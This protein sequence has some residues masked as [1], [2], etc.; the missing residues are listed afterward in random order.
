MA[1]D[2][3]PVNKSSR[4]GQELVNLSLAL[5]QAKERA[6]QVKEK[7][8][9]MQDGSDFAMIA[10]EFGLPAGS[11]SGQQAYNAVS[12]ALTALGD[13]S[14]TAIIQRIG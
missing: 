7:M 9:H 4:L 8:D 3:I 12:A 1:I 6:V 2:F 13:S 10:T 14:I 11:G 5:R